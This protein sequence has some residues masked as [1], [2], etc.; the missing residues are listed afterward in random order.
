MLIFFL[1]FNSSGGLGCIC[2]VEYESTCRYFSHHSADMQ[3]VFTHTHKK[4]RTEKLHVGWGMDDWRTLFIPFFVTALGECVPP[5]L[6]FQN[7][8]ADLLY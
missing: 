4:K 3:C 5:Y 6:Q 1:K 7:R 8:K 2:N